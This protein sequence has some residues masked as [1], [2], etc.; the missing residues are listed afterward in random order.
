VPVSSFLIALRAQE[1]TFGGPESVMT[2]TSVFVDMAGKYSIS[3]FSTTITARIV[4]VLPD[5]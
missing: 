1:I 5:P 2:V 4:T 3:H